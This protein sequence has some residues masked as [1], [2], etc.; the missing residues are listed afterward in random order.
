[1]MFELSVIQKAYD[2]I[3]WY[4]PIINRMPRGYKFTLGDRLQM[5]LLNLLEHLVRAKQ[6]EDRVAELES[7]NVV[8]EMIRHLTRLAFDFGMM[9]MKRYEYISIQLDGVGV[10]IGSWL[11]ASRRKGKT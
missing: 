5:N 11:K 1:M 10:E 7:A 2:L 6:K 8:L 9:N 4:V 3:K